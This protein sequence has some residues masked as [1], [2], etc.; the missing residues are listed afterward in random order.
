MNVSTVLTRSEPIVP[1]ANSNDNLFVL[2]I[3]FLLIGIAL[4]RLD[5]RRSNK[6]EVVETPEQKLVKAFS[7]YMKIEGH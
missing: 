7:E 6:S 3:F 4:A 5:G 1:V 2:Y